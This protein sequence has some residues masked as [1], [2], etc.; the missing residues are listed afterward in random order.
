MYE[1]S[2]EKYAMYNSDGFQMIWQT[3]QLSFSQL[4][5]LGR[6]GGGCTFSIDLTVGSKLQMKP[7]LDWKEGWDAIKQTATIWLMM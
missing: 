1:C 5:T 3:L 7:W 2:F 4:M 6:G